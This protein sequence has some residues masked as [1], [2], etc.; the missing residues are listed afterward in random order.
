MA[1][2]PVST[3]FPFGPGHP[4]RIDALV[5]DRHILAREGLRAMLRG[6]RVQLTA[7]TEDAEDALRLTRR[8]PPDIVFMDLRMPVMDGF[9]ALEVIKKEFGQRKFKTVAISASA[10]EHQRESTLS[11]GFDD[12]I[13]KPFQVENIFNCLVKLL[14]VRFIGKEKKSAAITWIAE[15]VLDVPEIHLPQALL[16]R[17]KKAADLS[18]LTD[19]KIC[20]HELE[21]L[22]EEGQSL[23]EYLKPLVSRYDMN[24]ILTLL[25]KVTNGPKT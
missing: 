1:T 19:L 20:M 13:S 6:S 23:L 9:Q 5:V 11:K 3:R 21:S 24:G 18:S 2:A 8:Q 22:G 14:E 7:D 25:K 4:G 17:L 15:K 10:F 16:N 12:F